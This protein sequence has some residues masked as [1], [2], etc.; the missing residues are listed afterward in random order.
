[1][2][3]TVTI[4]A[5]IL[6]STAC[7]PGKPKCTD[8]DVLALVKQIQT[9][10]WESEA[11]ERRS[12]YVEDLLPNPDK[13]LAKAMAE[14][15]SGTIAKQL[16]AQSFELM[17]SPDSAK[18]RKEQMAV[19][20]A[21]SARVLGKVFDDVIA[22]VQWDNSDFM[23]EET[24][25]KV[26]TSCK[27]FMQLKARGVSPSRTSFTYR[28]RRTDDQKTLVASVEHVKFFHLTPEK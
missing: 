5:L 18:A 1:M 21:D 7:S 28:V 3:L 6:I 4:L 23:T 25:S 24:D 16:I 17:E 10:Q 14:N 15:P 20:L 11:A 12:G 8:T 19:R 13:D 9:H 2:K 27:A 22:T 26:E